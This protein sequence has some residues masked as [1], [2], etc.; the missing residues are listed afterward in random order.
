V[1][2]LLDNTARTQTGRRKINGVIGLRVPTEVVRSKCRAYEQHGKPVHRADRL[3]DSPFTI[4]SM[5]QQEYRGV[6]EYYR[7]AF[8]LHRL[9]RLKWVME[10]S[11]AKTLAGKLRL[12]V[13]KVYRR[14]GATLH[15][16]NGTYKGLRV[17]VEREGKAPLVA[18][19]GGITL[20]RNIDAVLDDQPWRIRTSHS[21]L[22][23]RLLADACELCGSQE[24]IEVHHIR[25][26]KDLQ[27]PGRRPKPAWAIAMARRFR[28][29]LVLCHAC[30]Q[31]V[32]HG[33]PRRHAPEQARRAT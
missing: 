7:L 9:N 14:F 5:F 27:R 3:Q 24:Q 11:L 10:Q 25:A 29:T 21:E 18:Q 28:K 4:L 20:K 2:V 15:T 8:N 13:A 17:T 33:R 31:D 30:H 19:W 1:C 12:S 6:V 26:L 22:E 16:P 23:Q 32:Q